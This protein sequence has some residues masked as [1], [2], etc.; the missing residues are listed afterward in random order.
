M[1][2]LKSM[3]CEVGLKTYEKSSSIPRATMKS[4]NDA[5]NY[6][7]RIWE[8]D[9]R[10]HECF[11][12]VFMNRS[13][14]VTKF[15]IISKGE[16]SGTIVDLKILTK[17]ALDVLAQSVI[18]CHNHPSGSVQ[19]SERDKIITTKIKEALGY[20]DIELFDHI[21]LTNDGYY[22]FSDEGIL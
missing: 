16:V 13:N 19:P 14:N 3:V 7:R 12:A 22:S 15:A 5:Q 2:D 9:I 11:Y 17:L 20:F 1:N 18:V 21:I 8:E 6:F 4:S 10:I